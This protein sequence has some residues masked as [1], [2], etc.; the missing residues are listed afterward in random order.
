MRPLARIGMELRIALRQSRP[1]D[2]DEHFVR[3]AHGQLFA[4]RW[5]DLHEVVRARECEG[6]A[7]MG[8]GGVRRDGEAEGGGDFE[9][10]VGADCDGG[11][12][13]S[14]LWVGA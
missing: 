2:A 3:A 10:W 13:G 6:G 4:D 9:L 1:V 11:E 14:F 12:E 8:E 7:L 5:G